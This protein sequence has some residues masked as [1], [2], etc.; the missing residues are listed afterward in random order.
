VPGYDHPRLIEGGEAEPRTGLLWL[1]AISGGQPR[2]RAARQAL[3]PHRHDLLSTPPR[4]TR[5]ISTGLAARTTLVLPV[6]NRF[7]TPHRTTT[8]SGNNFVRLNEPAAAT[9]SAPI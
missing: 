3:G 4:P 9:F 1:G 7:E 2:I 5:D 6:F 8:E